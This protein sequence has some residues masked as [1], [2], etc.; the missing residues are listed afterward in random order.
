M[1]PSEPC[2]L[3]SPVGDQRMRR[4]PRSSFYIA[5]SSGYPGYYAPTVTLAASPRS[6][7]ASAT[8]STAPSTAAATASE[9]LMSNEAVPSIAPATASLPASPMSDLALVDPRMA[10]STT[11]RITGLLIV[12]ASPVP[13]MTPMTYHERRRPLHRPSRPP[14]APFPRRS[15]ALGC[16]RQCQR[17]ESPL[18]PRGRR[19]GRHA[20]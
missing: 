11:S 9:L 14:L 15:H 4:V 20:R 18:P 2:G 8:A 13:C 7:P 5:P 6:P 10:P 1:A 16:Q 17:N 12:S 3:N 19:N